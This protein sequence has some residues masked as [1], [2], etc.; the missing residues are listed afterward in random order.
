MKINVQCIKEEIKHEDVDAGFFKQPKLLPPTKYYTFV[1]DLRL[2]EFKTYLV[3][4]VVGEVYELNLDITE[5]KLSKIEINA[6]KV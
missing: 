1:D 5:G 6:T 2:F 3:K 4:G